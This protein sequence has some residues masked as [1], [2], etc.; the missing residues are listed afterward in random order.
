MAFCVQRRRLRWAGCAKG[1]IVCTYDYV[2]CIRGS[3]SSRILLGRAATRGRLCPA[4]LQAAKFLS[5]R[6][7]FLRN[8][9][10]AQEER[11]GW[12]GC[13]VPP[14][15]YLFKVLAAARDA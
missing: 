7:A 2:V 12:Q 15:P 1:E 4:C 3:A 8:K 11:M 14:F 5:Q 10:K 9:C 13:N 6:V